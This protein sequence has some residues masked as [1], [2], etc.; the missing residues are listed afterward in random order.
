MQKRI[1]L[2]GTS[3]VI[4][5]ALISSALGAFVTAADLSGKKI[6]L[7]NGNINTYMPD[8]KFSSNRVGEGTWAVTANG[9]QI[10]AEHW[11]GLSA[12][13]KLPDGTFVIRRMTGR[14][15]RQVAGKYCN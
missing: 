4:S 3:S 10:H 6:C 2:L 13:E 7:D 15:D 8:G 11:S 5:I 9:V 14:G 12:I 1:S